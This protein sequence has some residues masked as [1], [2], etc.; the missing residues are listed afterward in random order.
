MK[1][2]ILFII[3]LLWFFIIKDSSFAACEYNDQNLSTFL[4]DC[5]PNNVVWWADLTVTGWFKTKIN[6]WV[7]NIALVLWI[8]A[9][10]SLVYAGM[11]MQFSAWEDE[12]TKKA[13]DIIKWTII[14]FIGLISA[15]GIIYIVIN[16]MYWLAW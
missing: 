2:L 7:K 14:W 9:V 3:I 4:N 11:L 13:K 5:K 8:L 6:T 1:K 12:K 16:L 15:S 10:W